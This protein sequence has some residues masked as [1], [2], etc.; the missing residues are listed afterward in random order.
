MKSLLVMISVT[1]LLVGCSGGGLVRD[2]AAGAYVGLD[3]AEVRLLT[4]LKVAAGQARVFVQDGGVPRGRTPYIGGSF[5]QYRPH[6]AFE[7]RHVDHDGVII[8]PDTFRIV[9][10]QDSLQEVV[11]AEGTQV[12]GI[13]L[14]IGYGV[15]GG[16]ASYHLGYHF[17]LYSERQPDVMRMSCYGVYAERYD[18]EAPT[19]AEIRSALRNVAEIRR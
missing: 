5:D 2:T 9:R 7:I 10:T 3:G 8:E 18:L 14:M 17:T 4:P 13:G 16:S 11:Q 15:W 1:L 19:L 6:C 12:A